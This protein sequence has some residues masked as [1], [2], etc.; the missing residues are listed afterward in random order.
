M[1]FERNVPLDI[2]MILMNYLRNQSA[3]IVWN[4]ESGEYFAIDKGVRQGG[5]L[6]PF[7]LKLYIDGIMKKVD[8]MGLGCMLSPV[9]INILAYVHDLV[10]ISDTQ[11]HL[12]KDISKIAR[13]YTGVKVLSK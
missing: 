10:L 1:L 2:V 3:K 5:I 11:K 8:E 9:R 12:E 4:G 13:V 6:L 7:L